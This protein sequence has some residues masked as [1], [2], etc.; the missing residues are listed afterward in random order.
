MLISC[1]YKRAGSIEF[2]FESDKISSVR[3]SL[4]KFKEI[5]VEYFDSNKKADKEVRAIY[6][7][8]LNNIRFD[9]V[10]LGNWDN[11]YAN[12]DVIFHS[13]IKLDLFDLE[14]KG[15]FTLLKFLNDNFI[16]GIYYMPNIR[17]SY[18]PYYGEPF[19][20]TRIL[21]YITLKSEFYALPE[22]T[23]NFE[24]LFYLITDDK[25]DMLLLSDKRDLLPDIYGSE[26][27]APEKW[28]HPT[29]EIFYK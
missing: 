3:D 9:G 5:A 24:L 15:L 19:F 6:L 2:H 8:A 21:K 10:E 16:N 27:R 28:K 26:E 7:T 11:F 18:F 25:E 13:N 20:G 1:N 22:S 17:Y 12:K 4:V 14:R 23:R 29:D